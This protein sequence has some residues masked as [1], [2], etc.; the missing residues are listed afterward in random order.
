MS[1]MGL[2]FKISLL[3]ICTLGYPL[4]ASSS[5]FLRVKQ[6]TIVDESGKEF[7]L[8]GM[9]LGGW[10]LQE[11]YMLRMPGGGS[12]QQIKAK[13]T[14]LIGAELCEKFYEK[15]LSNH[16]TKT[17]IDSLAKWGFNSVRLPMHY[18]LFT[19][20]IELEPHPNENTWLSKGFELTDSLVS[21]CKANNMYVIL[22][23]H[24]APGGQGKDANISDY[25]ST[26]PS[27]WE[28]DLNKKKTIALWARIAEHYKDEPN[29][30]GYDLLNEP[31]WTFEN[32]DIHGTEDLLNKDIW[33][34]YIEISKAIRKVDKKH[35]LFI[36]G[37]GWGNNFNGLPG[38][39]DD[40]MV[41]SF[42]KYWNPNT[43]QS[44]GPFLKLRKKY[45]IPLWL[46]ESGENSN[47]W[48]TDCIRLVEKNH[49]GWSWW[50]LKKVSSVVN[51][52][53]ISAPVG[54]DQLLKYWEGGNLKPSKD[55]AAEVLFK[56][57]DN[58]KTEN[59]AFNEGVID[60]MFRQRFETNT[61][62]YT[63]NFIPGKIYG[64][65][66][67]LGYYKKAYFD[68]DNENITVEGKRTFGNR[69]NMYRNDGVD[70]KNS[71]N[72]LNI[73]NNRFHVFS[74]NAGEWLKFTVNIN[75]SGKYQLLARIK[76][77]AAT[78]K[79][80]VFL[81]RKVKKIEFIQHSNNANYWQTI[82]CGVI[83]LEK[84]ES[85]LRIEFA[86]NDVEFDFL[87][88]IEK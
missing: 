39:W 66:Y 84:G 65:D 40:N 50:P 5:G 30:G 43:Q 85:Q 55:F 56:L 16:V 48:F 83:E 70:I 21:W 23:L 11:G 60:A 6:H 75:K 69:G 73:F 47:K 1:K 29:I 12:Q 32:K 28:S 27:L 82:D 15:W 78:V 42:H 38:K 81:G 10:M 35:I 22:D 71:D 46:G 19:L 64:V 54:Y 57:T 77:N 74:I 44:I 8:R 41:L 51:P 4:T 37:N 36:E 3:L 79:F 62:P 49:I 26:K 34:L 76:S 88:F 53:T 87:E 63:N 14:D 18:N 52:L 31:N 68:S 24:A 80:N 45:D 9:G 67:D 58:L 33:D 72:Q 59:C 2:I 61:L 17:D 25:D 86:S 20:P 7:L 13:I